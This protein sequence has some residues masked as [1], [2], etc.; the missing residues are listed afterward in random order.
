[1][2]HVKWETNG[3][4]VLYDDLVTKTSKFSKFSATPLSVK[5]NLEAFLYR[6]RT[7]A[8]AWKPIHNLGIKSAISVMVFTRKVCHAHNLHDMIIKML[9]G[10]D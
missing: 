6:A 5:R 1:M 10:G 4:Q 2:R 3:F 8:A 9:Q 7:R